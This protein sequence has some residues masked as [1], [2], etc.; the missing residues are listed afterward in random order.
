[1]TVFNGFDYTIIALYV[2]LVTG[3][4]IFYS[5]VASNSLE[6]YYLANRRLPWWLLGTS[7]MAHFLDMTGTMIIVS[8]LYM[9]GPRGL[10]IEFRGGACLCLAFMLCWTGKWHR[11]SQCMTRAEWMTYRFGE[12]PS[13]NAARALTAIGFLIMS[14]GMIAY[15]MKGA[16]LFLGMFLP[17]P[18][19]ICAFALM[20]VA[21]AYTMSAGFFGV[22]ITDLVQSIIVL[23]GAIFISYLAIT[24]INDVPDFAALSQAVTGNPNWIQTAPSWHTPMP[25]GYEPYQYLIMFAFFYV[26]RNVIAGMGSGDDP[27]FFAARSDRECGKLTLL[28]TS[29]LMLRWPMM[30]GFAVMG[31]FLVRDLFPDQAVLIQAAE[32][33]KQYHP[34]IT[35]NFWPDL[36]ARIANSPGQYD[37]GLI[38]GLQSLLGENWGSR[39]AMLSF[40]GTINPER[41][42]PAVLL[43]QIPMGIRGMLVV[44]LIAAAMSTFDSELNIACALFV[45][46]LY[47]RF[48]RPRAGTSELIRASRVACVV[49]SFAGF[50]LGC[51]TESINDIWGWIIMGLGGGLIAPMVLRMYWWRFNGVGFAT[52]IFLGMAGAV[53]QRILAPGMVEWKQFLFMLTL[54]LVGSV[55]GTFLAK[56]TDDKTLEHFYR[57]TRPFGFWG[58]LKAKLASAEREAM[59]REHRNDILA[60]PFTLMWQ[61]TLFLMAMQIV[62]QEF[63]DFALT[64]PIFLIGGIGMYYFWYRNLP[65][66]EPDSSAQTETGSGCRGNS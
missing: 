55:L 2:V 54:S 24:H 63:R 6:S 35:K 52:G 45:R 65:P 25:A 44:C 60:L 15:L 47:Q 27:K 36:L 49:I 50:L 48:M 23:I 29:L 31:V 17:F 42:L 11:R 43:Y 21:G 37:G 9:L 13:G 1:M 3:I 58:P 64:L 39:L 18:P 38:A 30:I 61:V 59:E 66:E 62:I 32:L 14:I 34:D 56:P 51:F 40:E 28:W 7:G 57:T 5:R 33:I 41:I 26:L 20:V 53:L 22:V 4:G 16:G 19:I 46:D 12:G 8:F 10:Y